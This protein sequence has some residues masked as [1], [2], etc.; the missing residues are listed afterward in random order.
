ME[1][2]FVNLKNTIPTVYWGH[3][4]VHYVK[5]SDSQLKFGCKWIFQMN[6]DPLNTG[7]IVSKCLKNNK[8][9]VLE[10]ASQSCEKCFQFPIKYLCNL[11][12]QT[13]LSYTCCQEEWARIPANY[14]DKLVEGYTKRLS[15]D[16]LKAML[17]NTKE[18]HVNFW[19][20][21]SNKN[22]SKIFFLSLL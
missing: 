9:N 13:S 16:S 8:V 7:I 18:M 20:E 3:H 19:H 10:W 5:P 11:C 14:C 21:E 12:L 15:Q 2:K 1:E 4:H 17:P 6:N 22:H